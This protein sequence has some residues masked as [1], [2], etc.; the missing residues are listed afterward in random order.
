MRCF[1]VYPGTVR[2]QGIYCLAIVSVLIVAAPRNRLNNRNQPTILILSL[3]LLALFLSTT[4]HTVTIFLATTNFI[5]SQ[6]NGSES[7]GKF[8]YCAPTATL[9]IN[10]CFPPV[11][12]R[13]SS[14]I[15]FAYRYY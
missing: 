6:V 5:F 9:T 1:F 12:F 11:E 13:R 4:I 2:H 15:T 8:L 7:T 10:V 3:A 14:L